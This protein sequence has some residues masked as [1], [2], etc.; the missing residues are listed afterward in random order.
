VAAPVLGDRE[1][2][3]EATNEAAPE[4]LEAVIG[5]HVADG[6][7]VRQPDDHRV[8]LRRGWRRVRVAVAPG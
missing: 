4:I 7:S 1:T 6:W 3:V 8:V 2:L 5:R